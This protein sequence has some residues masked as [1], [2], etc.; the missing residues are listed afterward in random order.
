MPESALVGHL[1]RVSANEVG[2]WAS[3]IIR[4]AYLALQLQVVPAKRA[5]DCTTLFLATPAPA[6]RTD[7]PNTHARKP[8]AIVF[9]P[10]KAL[11]IRTESA[12]IQSTPTSIIHR[13]AW[14]SSSLV[15]AGGG[16][17]GIKASHLAYSV[18]S[19]P[20]AAAEQPYQLY[21]DDAELRVWNDIRGCSRITTASKD[22]EG[23][24]RTT[25]DRCPCPSDSRS[26]AVG[27]EPFSTVLGLARF[28]HQVRAHLV[29]IEP[30]PGHLQTRREA[31]TNQLTINTRGHTSLPS[32]SSQAGPNRACNGK[33]GCVLTVNCK[34]AVD[35]ELVVSNEPIG[36]RK[37]EHLVNGLGDGRDGFGGVVEG[38]R[39]DAQGERVET[40]LPLCRDDDDASD[41]KDAQFPSWSAALN[42][43]TAPASARR[44][45]IC[46]STP[47]TSTEM[48][49]QAR[50]PARRRQHPT[51][52][53]EPHQTH[54][55]VVSHPHTRATDTEARSNAQSS[56]FLQKASY[57]KAN[58]TARIDSGRGGAVR[59]GEGC[60]IR[61]HPESNAES[62]VELASRLETSALNRRVSAARATACAD[63][64]GGLALSGRKR[65]G[66][67]AVEH[68]ARSRGDSA[69][70]G[71]CFGFNLNS[72]VAS[73]P[74]LPHKSGNVSAPSSTMQANPPTRRREEP[75][76]ASFTTRIRWVGIES[77][78][79]GMEKARAGASNDAAWLSAARRYAGMVLTGL[80]EGL[81]SGKSNE[82][83]PLVRVGVEPTH[84]AAA[85]SLD[86]LSDSLSYNSNPG[87]SCA[88]AFCL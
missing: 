63:P 2:R 72:C 16:P 46:R 49:Q 55:L 77:V 22:G 53:R 27:S 73:P 30:T 62:R 5:D 88:P 57:A 80:S 35:V 47:R 67:D 58:A 18:Y 75:H 15:L 54:R 32:T 36:L 12:T 60:K 74:V 82:R 19:S 79:Y 66:I 20:N 69:S 41:E 56:I 81:A 86:F 28:P 76:A 45:P 24:A 71:Q 33:A 51:Q 37:N 4:V 7:S 84:D 38:W 43:P 85:P 39:R 17:L 13:S 40:P 6:A 10:Q 52:T 70:T 34:T 87:E 14:L 64:A 61:G 23:L 1:V 78:P 48:K 42:P 68:A 65:V 59:H 8:I 3:K 21:H 26:D 25:E 44:R 50:K 83:A 11:R 31:A 9:S 29:R